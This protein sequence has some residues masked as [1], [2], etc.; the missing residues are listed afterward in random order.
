MSN[1]PKISEAEY[2]VM[3]TLWQES[4]LTS[5]EIIDRLSK[6]YKWSSQTIKIF[7]TRLSK[8]EALSYEKKGRTYYY[9]PLI[10]EKEALSYENKSF[11]KRVYDGAVGLLI[12]NFIQ[13]KALT[14]DDINEIEKILND[15]KAELAPEEGDDV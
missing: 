4:P 14:L 12:S 3:K 6:R 9:Y 13:D 2:E 7:I 15:K 5:E 8:K 11:L 1:L 10:S